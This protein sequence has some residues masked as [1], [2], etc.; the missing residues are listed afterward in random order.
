MKKTLTLIAITA[1]ITSGCSIMSHTVGYPIMQAYANKTLRGYSKAAYT[2]GAYNES[3]KQHITDNTTPNV[4][5]D[6][7]GHLK[8][9]LVSTYYSAFKDGLLTVAPVKAA[10]IEPDDSLI[11]EVGDVIEFKTGYSILDEPGK[12]KPVITK[13]VCRKKDPD[14]EKCWKDPKRGGT[15]G[16]VD[17]ETG[18]AHNVM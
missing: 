17:P 2:I 7:P 11:A 10:A 18:I 14:F 8:V 15:F 5:I 16:I 13:I 3:I 9:H 6:K 4:Y 12:T 1:T